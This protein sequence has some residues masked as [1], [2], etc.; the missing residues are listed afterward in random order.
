MVVKREIK[1]F[2]I[3]YIHE[4]RTILGVVAYHYA[5]KYKVPYVLQAAGSLPS[6]MGRMKILKKMFDLLFGYRML[7]DADM[8]IARNKREVEQYKNMGVDEDK[9]EIVPAGIDLSE[10]VDL[11]KRGEFRNK[12][13]I[14]D[15]EKIILYLGRIHKIKGIDL[16]V[17][18]FADLIKELDN[19][20]L[21]IAG[22]NDGFLS[23]LKKQI[24]DLKI[25]DKI[26]LTG[27][28]YGRDKLESYVDADVYVLPSIYEIF[29]ITVL[30]ACA[31]GTPVVVTDRCGIAEIVGKAGYVV[32]YD[33]EQ[34]R[35]AIFKILNNEELR[36]K[37]SER[38]R[39]L[40]EKNFSWNLIAEK[41]EML[42]EHIRKRN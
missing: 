33:K 28:L 32:E 19:V 26:L 5:R 3:V 41:M 1:D 38:G 4:Y 24:K 14:K 16:L 34:L 7:H 22:P 42:Y 9:I 15:D 27:P 40:I 6:D 18:A 29:G 21:V 37:F 11:P 17:E 39:K 12:Y 36:K 35:D 31:C 13:S 30:E 2:D 10:Y 20:R 23:P 8:L 25:D